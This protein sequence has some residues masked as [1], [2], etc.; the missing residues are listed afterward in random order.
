MRWLDL[1]ECWDIIESRIRDHLNR[2]LRRSL[3]LRRLVGPA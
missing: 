1:S 3:G 2:A